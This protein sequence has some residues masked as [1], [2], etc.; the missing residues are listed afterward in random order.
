MFIVHI[1]MDESVYVLRT[2]EYIIFLNIVMR[3]QPT[4]RW[5]GA[6][7]VVGGL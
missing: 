4:G 2:M 7:S 1:R 5:L 6:W 3:G